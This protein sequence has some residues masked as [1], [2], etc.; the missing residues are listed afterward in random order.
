VGGAESHGLRK[1]IKLYI[2]DMDI[3]DAGLR[4]I[5]TAEVCESCIS[6]RLLIPARCKER[7]GG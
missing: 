2:P 1:V 7:Q 5:Q 6:F 4:Q 3:T